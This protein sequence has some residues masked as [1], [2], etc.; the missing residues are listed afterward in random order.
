MLAITALLAYLLG[1]I[2]FGLVVARFFGVEDIRRQGSGNIGATNVGRIAGFRAA[3]WVYVGDIGKGVL[4]VL[5]ARL[6]AG[7]T[8]VSYISVDLFLVICALAAVLGHIFPVYIGFRGGKGVNTGLGVMITLLPYETLLAVGVFALLVL[9]TRY[10]SLGSICA[11]LALFA[12]VA[13]EKHV[14]SRDIAAVYFYLTL[15]LAIVVIVTHRQN[16]GRL[17]S[18]TENRISFGASGRMGSNG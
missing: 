11:G 10:V 16:I 6:V 12:F 2:P 7:N 14:L 3:L 17:L 18:G 1:A 8:D 9:V 5:L 13:V 4:A 15:A